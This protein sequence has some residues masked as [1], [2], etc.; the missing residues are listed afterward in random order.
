MKRLFNTILAILIT[1]TLFAQGDLLQK[2]NGHY[3]KDEFNEA[4]E[5]YNQILMSGLESKE[6][7]FNL[8]NAY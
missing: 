8:G 2:A 1:T 7:Y 4:I 5:V 6:V 3:V